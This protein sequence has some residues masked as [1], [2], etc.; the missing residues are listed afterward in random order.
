MGFALMLG[1]AHC[2][3]GRYFETGQYLNVLHTGVIAGEYIYY[4]Y[5]I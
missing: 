4:V 3:V 5:F 2:A 1:K